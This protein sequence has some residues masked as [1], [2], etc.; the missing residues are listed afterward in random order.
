M[1]LEFHGDVPELTK[2]L[3]RRDNGEVITSVRGKTAGAL[4]GAGSFQ[5]TSAVRALSA[6]LVRGALVTREQGDPNLVAL[7]GFGQSLAS[8]LDYALSK[9]PLWTVEMC[10]VDMCGQSFLRRLFLR[11][12]PERK[13]PG[14]VIINLNPRILGGEAIQVWWNGQ[15]LTDPA[16]FRTLLDRVEKLVPLGK[17]GGVQKSD[18]QAERR[19]VGAAA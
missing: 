6:I 11:T 12:N 13:Y 5:W 19:T 7:S 4:R 16:A 9:Q 2:T 10:G 18:R 17:K 8:T 14:P 3:F 1:L 15:R